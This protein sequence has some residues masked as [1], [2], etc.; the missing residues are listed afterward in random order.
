MKHISIKGIKVNRW[1]LFCAMALLTALLYLFGGNQHPGEV[2]AEVGAGAIVLTEEE[3]AGMTEAEQKMMIAVKKLINHNVEDAKKGLIT[4]T[5]LQAQIKELKDGL[6]TQEIKA[7]KDEITKMEGIL[8]TQGTE[9]NALRERGGE[10]DKGLSFEEAWESNLEAIKEIRANGQ[11]FKRFYFGE[12]KAEKDKDGNDKKK[13]YVDGINRMFKVAGVTSVAN[14]T[15]SSPTQVT[16]PYSPFPQQL[17]EIIGVRRNPNFATN[18]VDVGSTNAAV[19]T[20]TEEGNSEGDA[21]I[22]TEGNVKPLQDKKFI[23]RISKY[24]KMAGHIIVTEEMEEDTPR[25]ATSVRRL[26]QENVMRKYDDQVWA[27]IIAVAPGY[28]STALDDQI[29]NADDYAA[30]GAA[31]CQLENLNAYPDTICINPSDKWRMKLQ[32]GTDGHYVLPPFVVGDRTF[33]SVRV[34]T[35]NKV[36]AGNFLVAEMNKYKVDIYKSFSLRV[37]WQNDDLVKNQFTIVGEIKFH[38]Y[39]ATNDLVGFCYAQFA[40]VKAAI[41]KP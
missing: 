40:T 34:V 27:D 19:L 29:D 26:F 5:Q 25:I 4:S 7:L 24:K 38:S 11:G 18:Y 15:A 9:L 8:K 39:V 23:D 36:A 3:K 2:L 33:D 30:I 12:V 21:A 10:V 13:K 14:S 22:T 1:M 16:N 35:S 31:F 20:W 17:P 32:K 37:G 28:T 6:T 41:E